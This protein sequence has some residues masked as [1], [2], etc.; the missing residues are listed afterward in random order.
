MIS[1]CQEG[2]K[3][4]KAVAYCRVSTEDQ[5]VFGVSLAAQEDKARQYCTLYGLE[6]SEVITDA[7][8]SAKNLHRPG[9]QRILEM[10][11]RREVNT[12]VV[13][14]L[15]RITR[16]VRDLADIVDLFNKYDVALVSVAESLDTRSAAGRMVVNMLGVVS[17]WEREAIGERTATA[18]QY[19]RSQ[20]KSY[21]GRQAPYGYTRQDG[22]LVSVDSEQE[23]IA[24]IMGMQ[25]HTLADIGRALEA[26]GHRTRGGSTSWHHKMI[27]KILEDAAGREKIDGS[28]EALRIAA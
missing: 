8:I 6:L 3:I 19:K 11:R 28:N 2:G 26:Q 7:G 14:K 4:M 20:G 10:V 1:N 9:A 17:Q 13:A 22:R 27:G 12:V 16:S 15:D 21:S 25:G 18:I 23:V 24:V 5:K